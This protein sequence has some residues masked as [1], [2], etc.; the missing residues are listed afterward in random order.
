MSGVPVHSARPSVPVDEGPPGGFAPPALRRDAETGGT[1][2]DR[3]AVASR[4]FGRNLLALIASQFVTTPVS[5][6]VNAM[7]ARALGADSFGAIYLATTVLTLAFLLVDWGGQ[8]QIAAEIA[9]DRSAAPRIFGTGLVF[10][11]A[12]GAGMLLGLP[13]FA[14]A[15]DYSA[16]VRTAL[17]LGAFRFALSTIGTLCNAVMRGY[18]RVHWHAAATVTGTLLDAALVIGTLVAGGKLREALVAQIVAAALTLV[19]QVA[20]VLRLGF[21]RPRVS[22]QAFHALIGG[23]FSFFM[24]EAVLYAQPYIDAS[25]LSALAPAAALGWYSAATRV[26]GVLVFPSLAM[27]LA[28]YPTLARLWTDDRVTYQTMVQLALRAVTILGLLAATGTVIFA[29]TVVRLV[30]GDG[31]APAAVN[32]ALLSVYVV[33]VYTN[34]LL[35]T[36]LV[37][38]RKQVKW[39]IVQSLCLVGSATLNP[40]LIPWAQSTY[41][42]GGAGV[43]IC[44]GLVEIIMTALGLGLLPNG[45]LQRS[46]LRTAVSS[47]IAAAGLVLVAWLC[48]GVTWLA[49]TLSIPVY[50]GLIWLQGEV[51]AD[52]LLL[53]RSVIPFRTGQVA[54]IQVTVDRA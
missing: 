24:L 45:V 23:G 15:M 53:L 29:G 31:Y 26:T 47:V 16:I 14:A 52:L 2:G 20:L 11:L 5:L 12:L 38:A 44:V 7:L 37:A 34:I 30:Y 19:L 17:A 25:F 40:T 4:I 27:N 43:C 33:F 46:L 32:L 8:A 21:G 9:R 6:V 36:V 28:L 41:G 54:A 1:P 39:A 3:A 18:E 35:G 50:F 48:G 49:L 10:R 22:P 13:L 42:N 51:D